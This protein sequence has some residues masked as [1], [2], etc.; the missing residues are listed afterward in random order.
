MKKLK[1]ISWPLLG[2]LFL[3]T[4]CKKS[5]MPEP[6]PGIS[7]DTSFFSV[8]WQV[9]LTPDTS[10]VLSGK[11]IIENG[12]II[13]VMGFSTP[14]NILNKRSGDSG[15]IIWSWNDSRIT[16]GS[17]TALLD[18]LLYKEGKVMLGSQRYSFFINSDNGQNIFVDNPGLATRRYLVFNSIVEDYIFRSIDPLDGPNSQ[19]SE[20]V[21][22]DLK[23]LESAK[24]A[25]YQP[26]END[27]APDLL[28]VTGY[29]NQNQDLILIF[30]N[31]Q[32]RFS[33]GRGKVDLISYNFS[34]DTLMWKKEDMTIARSSNVIP[35]VIYQDK[36]YFAGSKN[37][38]CLDLFTGDEIWHTNPSPTN[39]GYFTSHY[40]I[41]DDKLIVNDDEWNLMALE[42]ST[43][44]T[45]WHIP[46]MG[47]TNTLE[48]YG[49]ILFVSNDN[50]IAID[51][52]RGEII[53]N[54]PSPNLEVRPGA[55]FYSEGIGIDH[56]NKK[57]FVSD[58]Y[59]L[60]CLE[61]NPQ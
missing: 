36:I 5:P 29:R 10:E 19:F 60:I 21:Y 7:E 49:D 37:I 24:L 51:I 22:Y 14:D 12:D 39:S 38:Y 28:S 2:V 9:P 40:K 18:G 23:N 61:I 17:E 53:A 48:H 4:A 42:P 8:L 33:P 15:E 34:Q 43:G 41:I 58:G 26:N 20:L 55:S 52:K 1:S 57:V 13:N 30:Q 47:N 3:F 54:F 31:R 27:F 50:L 16:D 35:P 56:E 11:K 44:E 25:Y 45:L 46:E 32:Y 59:F 6:E